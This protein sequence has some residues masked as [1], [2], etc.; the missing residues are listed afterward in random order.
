MPEIARLLCERLG[1]RGAEVPTK[2]L[3]GHYRWRCRSYNTGQRREV[4]NGGAQHSLGF[5]PRPTAETLADC[6]RSL[7][8]DQR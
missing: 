1:P 8:A 3:P 5:N 7:N 4:S 6:A 2:V